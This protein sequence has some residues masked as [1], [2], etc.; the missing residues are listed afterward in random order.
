MTVNVTIVSPMRDF[1]A[2]VDDYR[3]RVQALGQ[4]LSALRFV[5]VEGDSVD[6]TWDRLQEWKASDWRVTLVK[7]NTGQPRYPSIIDGARFRALAAVFNAGLEAVRLDWSAS[8][9]FLP[10]DVTF[11]ADML[12]RLLAHDKDLIAPFFWGPGGGYFY[13]TWGFMWRGAHFKNFP[14]SQMAGRSEQPLQMDTI[15][16]AILMRADVL[17]AGCRYTPEEVDHGLCKAAQAL[18]F[19]VWAD[20]TTHIEHL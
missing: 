11:E 10:C 20:P 14:R 4:P 7:H 9:L 15:G 12:N 18:G 5:I 17:R 16:G 3:E 19:S 2:H 6:D 13:D 1:G 8:V